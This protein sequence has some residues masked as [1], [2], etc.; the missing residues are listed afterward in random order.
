MTRTG[1]QP[2]RGDDDDDNAGHLILDADDKNSLLP[3]STAAA[4]LAL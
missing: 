4:L 2:G 1:R 3:H